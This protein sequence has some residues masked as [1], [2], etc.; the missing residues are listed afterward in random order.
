MQVSS[1]KLPTTVYNNHASIRHLPGHRLRAA[2]LAVPADT[3]HTV[4]LAGGKFLVESSITDNTGEEVVPGIMNFTVGMRSDASPT[5]VS[6]AFELSV[7]MW[8]GPSCAACPATT[9]SRSHRAS[10][11][12]PITCSS[13][14]G[15]PLVRR[16]LGNLLHTSCAVPPPLLSLFPSS[17]LSSS[18]QFY[19]G[20]QRRTSLDSL[21]SLQL[22]VCLLTPG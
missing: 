11:R 6:S 14:P 2:D 22:A 19:E 3:N 1:P 17:L 4:E 18:F 15:L 21:L 13:I 20:R 7:S 9:S 10:A 12:S 16:V 5:S 8:A